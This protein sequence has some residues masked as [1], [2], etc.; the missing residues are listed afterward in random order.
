MFMNATQT[1]P[2]P[3]EVFD[4]A[5]SEHMIEH[6]T[7]DAGAIVLGQA[8]RVLRPGGVLRIVTPDLS[9]LTDLHRQDGDWTEMQSQYVREAFQ[10]YNEVKDSNAAQIINNFVRNWGHQFIYDFISLKKALEDAGFSE[11]KRCRVG[12]SDHE[13][14]RDIENAGRMPQGM[15]EFESIVMEGT[16][17]SPSRQ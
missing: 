14:L 16:K 3:G 4:F 7:H 9:F 15:L 12:E 2:F 10:N 13:E 8:H 6:V 5:F 11:V 1:W 17:P